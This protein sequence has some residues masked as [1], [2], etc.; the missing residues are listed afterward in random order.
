MSRHG[1]SES[2][3]ELTELTIY[4]SMADYSL[5]PRPDPL[6]QVGP[7]NEARLIIL[8]LTL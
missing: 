3:S 1:H 4:I 6:G 5:V 7:G 8:V 2:E